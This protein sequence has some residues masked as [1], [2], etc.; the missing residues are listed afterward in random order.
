M[1]GVKLSKQYGVNP[2]ILQCPICGKEFGLALFGSGLRDK[3]TRKEV[4]A[5]RKIAMPDQICDSCKNVLD[6]GG[7]F[8]I[9][10]KDGEAAKNS[11]NPYRTGRLIALKKEAAER[12]FKEIHP[13]SYM[14]HSVYEE[15]F[16]EAQRE[17]ESQAQDDKA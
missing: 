3:K 10:V 7:V 2:S 17:Y 9:E 8:F 16:G 13:V 14:E 1:S 6:Q 12:M 15:I 5:P 11:K 4:E